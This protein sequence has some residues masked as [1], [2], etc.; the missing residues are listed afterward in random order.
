VF[1]TNIEYSAVVTGDVRKWCSDCI[2]HE[3]LLRLRVINLP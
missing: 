2:C 3:G 1:E